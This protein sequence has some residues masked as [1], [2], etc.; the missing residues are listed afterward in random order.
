MNMPANCATKWVRFGRSSSERRGRSTSAF[1]GEPIVNRVAVTAR[2]AIDTPA[3][4]FDTY[5]VEWSRSA[6]NCGA[7][8]DEVNRYFYAPSLGAVVKYERDYG[9][10]DDK[11]PDPA[12]GWEAIRVVSPKDQALIAMSGAC[13][14]HDASH[15]RSV[16][17]RRFGRFRTFRPIRSGVGEGRKIVKT[18]DGHRSWGHVLD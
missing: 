14:Q 2:A 16:A 7:I 4:H 18:V 11:L 12:A 9:Y 17:R 6:A 10:G 3:G 13:A 1:T 8:L 5:V 15:R